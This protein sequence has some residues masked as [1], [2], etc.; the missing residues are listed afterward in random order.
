MAPTKRSRHDAEQDEETTDVQRARSNYRDGDSRKRAKVTLDDEGT[1]ERTPQR[2][3]TSSDDS[4]DDD[5]DRRQRNLPPQ[6]QYELMRDD[7]FKHLEHADW[8]DQQATQKLA[9][10][11]NTLGNNMV[12]ESGIIESITCFNF[13]CHE[14]LHVDLGPLIN[15]IVG[16]NGSGKSAVLTALTLCLGGKA[17]DTNRGGSLKS[18]VKEGTEQ[19][20]LVV[21]IKNAGSDA[22][23]PDIYGET[24]IVERHFSKSGSSGFK[25][26]S[27]NGRII[28]TK[29]QEVDEISEWYA[30]QIGNPLTVLSQ[31][32]ARQFLNA[33]TPAQKYKYFVSGVQL[34]QLDNDYKMSQ[35]TLDKTLMLRDDLTSKIEQV[36]KEME[37][38]KRLSETAQKNKTMREKARHY[39]NQ[40]VWFQVVEQEQSLAEYEK[41]LVRRAQTIIDKEQYCETTTEE[42]RVIEEKLEQ[43]RQAKEQLEQYRE[44]YEE[45]IAK[46]TEA[47]REA[48]KDESE[49]LMEE[50]DA[51]QRLK[52]IKD[53]IKACKSKI[54]EEERRLSQSTGNARAEKDNELEQARDKE[55]LLRQQME[56]IHNNLPDFQARLSEAEQDSKKLSHSKDIKRKDIVSVEQQVRELKATTGGRYDGYDKEIRDVVNAIENERGWEQK[57]VGPIGA[58]IRLSKPEWSGILERTLGEGLN[59][60]V[61]RSKSDQTRLSNLMRRFRLKKQPPIYIAY[62]GKIDTSSQEPDPAFDTILRVLQFDDDIVRSQL[63]IGNQIEKIILIR[64]RE[65]AQKVMVEGVP[66]RNVGAC[67]CFH[68]GQGKRGWGLR[69][70]NRNGS[71]ATS[72]V[73]PYTM[74]PRMQTDVGQQVRI[75][76]D[77]LKHLGQEMA[78]VSRRERQAQQAVQRCR[79]ELDNQRKDHRKL[80]GDLRR[81]QADIE[82]I[83]MELDAFEG[84]DGRL[85][86]LRTEL[87]SRRSD[88]ES[89]GNQYGEMALS[90]RD[91]KAKTEKARL[92]L[93]EA[94]NDQEEFEGKVQK[95][96]QKIAAAENMRRVSVAKKNDAFEQA[97]IERNERRRVEEKREHK[98]TEVAQFIEQATE[99]VPERVHIP[100]DETYDSIEQKYTKLREQLKQREA[101]IG[102]TDDQIFDR[103]NEAEERYSSVQRQTKDLDDTIA[104]LKRAIHSRL[105]MWRQFQRQISARIR[106]QFNYLLSERGFRGKIDLDHR[107]RKVHVQIEPDETR[108]SSS[109]R[110]TKT[111]SGGE[112][113]FSSICML[114][115]VW[116]AIGSPIRCLDEF[117]VFMD[118]V[119]RAISTNML[120]DVARRSVSRQYILIT[121]NAIEGRARLDKDV[122]IIR[123][124]DPR[125]R[126]LDEFR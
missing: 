66:P 65:E 62:G 73:Q 81:T 31:D 69:L 42:L 59:A 4:K 125:Q 24:I 101:R 29:K 61:V 113:S 33:A 14:R 76:E 92:K 70:T 84:V 57:P 32:N 54:Q 94:K 46:A 99:A 58:H 39:R 11:G 40:L 86:I 90:K 121:P 126:T 48:A 15:F 13:M 55:F 91:L 26:K 89:L 60:F 78:E 119:N 108:K 75:Q 1:I 36:R 41:D 2:E 10:R 56:E 23:Q 64:D 71:M 19:G 105:E 68:D 118:N 45:N 34:E 9:Q 110:N 102:A 95:A 18:F 30:L 35:D 74:R 53:D 3:E 28:S 44:S 120:V 83:Q 88:E 111:L 109:G 67:L 6:T 37:E 20:S 72:P 52:T 16:E 79:A 51:H 124:T 47:H 123:L 17:S 107:N 38:A 22:Y 117:D 77:N 5:D 114:L 8:D 93:E 115:S 103:S 85:N 21:K 87:E 112:K 27:T 25:I 96:S 104:S 80:E 116:E 82:R 12:S 7:G 50:R 122:K 98:A 100:D 97:D 43:R 49:L 63:I 106:I